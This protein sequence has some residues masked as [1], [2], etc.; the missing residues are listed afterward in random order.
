MKHPGVDYVNLPWRS[1][2]T[3]GAWI[4]TARDA[5]VVQRVGRRA[6]RGARGLKPLVTV[7]VELAKSR[8]PRGARGLKRRFCLR[9]QSCTCRA[10]RGARGL[11]LTV[12][13]V[14]RNPSGS[15]PTWGAWIETHLS[16]VPRR[17]R[18]CRAPRGA[19]GLKRL[20]ACY[21]TGAGLSRPTWG[22][23]IETTDRL[24]SDRRRSVAP[25]VGRV[26]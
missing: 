7:T 12:W 2:P 14:L 15:R 22:A 3:W 11:K 4:E 19:R 8:A 18:Y 1:R 9:F 26:D 5:V 25:H 24:L 13:V 10:P 6:P 17:A 16:A 20:I 21:Q 23:W